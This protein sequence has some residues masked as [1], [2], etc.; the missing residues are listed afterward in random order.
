MEGVISLSSWHI[1]LTGASSNQLQVLFWRTCW[2]NTLLTE[3]KTLEGFNTFG[4]RKRLW[5]VEVKTNEGQ[6]PSIVFLQ[7]CSWKAEGSKTRQIVTNMLSTHFYEPPVDTSRL[8]NTWTTATLSDA[9]INKNIAYHVRCIHDFITYLTLTHIW[10]YI[11]TVIWSVFV[12]IWSLSFGFTPARHHPHTVPVCF[13]SVCAALVS[14]LC[15]SRFVKLQSI[16][17]NRRIMLIIISFYL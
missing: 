6:T 15:L 9:L 2:Y 7:R 16:I 13:V 4:K 17:S 5:G 11:H 12:S 8:G 14:V 10:N 3:E 1:K